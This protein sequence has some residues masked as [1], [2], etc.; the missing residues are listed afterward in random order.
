MKHLEARNSSVRDIFV[1]GCASRSN[2]QTRN[3]AAMFKLTAILLVTPVLLGARCTAARQLQKHQSLPL[4][5]AHKQRTLQLSALSVKK[6]S[7]WWL[8]YVRSL[9]PCRCLDRNRRRVDHDFHLDMP[10]LLP[11]VRRGDG[12]AKKVRF[13]VST[14]TPSMQ[15]HQARC[16][17]RN[18]AG[19]GSPS[20]RSPSARATRF[21]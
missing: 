4:R 13:C 17:T 5:T 2:S 11:P 6:Q 15:P 14:A 1:R 20:R 16:S 8:S 3:S 7:P 21:R 19:P 9:G 12:A 18:R 10:S